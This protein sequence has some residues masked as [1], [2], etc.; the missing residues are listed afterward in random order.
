MSFMSRLASA[1]IS[2]GVCEVPGWGVELPAERVLGE[3]QQLGLA[4]TELGELGYLPTDPIELAELCARY[5]LAMIGGFVPLV[6]HDPGERDA[7]IAATRSAARLMSG[8]GGT[9]FITSGVTD[10]DW[11]PRPEID[12]SGWDHMAEMCRVVDEIVGEYGM[13]QAIHPHLKTMIERRDDVVRLLDT[14]EAGWTL[15]T[16]HLQIGGFDPLD[17]IEQAFDRIEH[18]HLKDVVMELAIP[19]LD[20]DQS[21]MDAV[22]EGVFCTLGDGDVAIGDIVK[23]LEERGYDRWYVLEQDTAI[24]SGIPDV[25]SGPILDVHKSIEFLSSLASSDTA[26]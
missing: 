20:G 24:T 10:W 19:V 9:L 15:D 25:G 13:R 7:T 21:I 3:M 18:V 8:A 26:A 22:Q 14:T 23:T 17:F 11:G 12:D 1:P 2:W 4:A 5:G 16:G 6:L